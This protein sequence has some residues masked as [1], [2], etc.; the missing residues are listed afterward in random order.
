MPLIL[1]KPLTDDNPDYI[2]GSPELACRK[3]EDVDELLSILNMSFDTE[4]PRSKLGIEH[5]LRFFVDGGYK[6][7]DICAHMR[8]TWPRTPK[9]QGEWFKVWESEEMNLSVWEYFLTLDR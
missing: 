7:G 1:S 5:V 8:Y 6:F 2:I 3:Y 9:L 4:I